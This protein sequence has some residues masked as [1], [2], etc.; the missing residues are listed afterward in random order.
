MQGQS[1][2]NFTFKTKLRNR[3]GEKQLYSLRSEFPRGWNVTFKPK[4][5]A[6][7]S[8]EIEANS[9]EDISIE[10]NPPDPR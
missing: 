7:T 6:A 8:V 9:S 2:S 1:K 10:I 5:K 4:Y 3:T